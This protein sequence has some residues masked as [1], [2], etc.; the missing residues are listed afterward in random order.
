MQRWSDLIK[1][2][3]PI[4]RCLQE[5]NFKVTEKWKVKGWN[6]V[7]RAPTNQCGVTTKSISEYRIRSSS[8]SSQR[9]IS[10]QFSKGRNK[11]SYWT[12]PTLPTCIKLKSPKGMIATLNHTATLWESRSRW[13]RASQSHMKLRCV[14][15]QRT[16]SK[17]LNKSSRYALQINA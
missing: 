7:Y 10:T 9:Y 8:I 15:Y 2:Q 3:E 14:A 1:E 5:T 17:M 6:K 11:R 12:P 13:L 4:L 16:D